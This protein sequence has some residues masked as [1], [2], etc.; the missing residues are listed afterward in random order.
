M[1]IN[2]FAGAVK[3][4]NIPFEAD[5]EAFLAFADRVTGGKYKTAIRFQKL[6]STSGFDEYEL[7][8]REGIISIRATSGTAGGAALNHYLRKY[9]HYYYGILTQSGKLPDVPPD[10]D[11]IRKDRSVFHYRYAFNYCTF[12]YTF[13]FYDQADW[14]RM[15]DYLILAGYNLVLNPVGNECVC[16]RSQ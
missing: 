8:A 10:T 13:A 4:K 14:E 9:C 16:S 11:G 2:D 6:E 5:A 1:N 3:R 12:G 7:E 15:T